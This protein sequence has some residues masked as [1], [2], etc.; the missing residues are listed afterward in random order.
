LATWAATEELESMGLNLEARASSGLGGDGVNAA[1]VYLGDCTTRDADQVMVVGGFAR[2]VGVSTVR[3]VNPLNKVLFSK[4]FEEAEDGGTPDTEVA[5]LR[6]VEKVCGGE[7]PLPT[8]NEGGEL[9]ARPGQANPRLVKRLEQ[10]LCHRGILPELRLSLNTG[11]RG[12][13]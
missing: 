7:V 2:D 4:E 9:T 13:N 1:V 11:P 12:P 10:L 3:Q 8:R 6:I 5:I